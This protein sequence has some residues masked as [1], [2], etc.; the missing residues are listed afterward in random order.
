MIL[1]LIRILLTTGTSPVGMGGFLAGL[2]TRMIQPPGQ[3]RWTFR[4][5]ESSG[6]SYTL[7]TYD[8]YGRP[9]VHVSRRLEAQG[10]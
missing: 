3:A 5:G 6:C 4:P 2:L 7:N 10:K 9:Y 8:L 1:R